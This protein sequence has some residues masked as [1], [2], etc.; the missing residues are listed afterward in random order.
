LF[1]TVGMSCFLVSAATSAGFGFDFELPE[2][3]L[4]GKVQRVDGWSRGDGCFLSAGRRWLE[5]M[6]SWRPW[7]SAL[8]TSPYADRPQTAIEVH[9]AE[10][11]ATA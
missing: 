1:L 4:C 9:E 3:I 2:G 8:Y 10:K 5:T 7:R 6:T 11:K